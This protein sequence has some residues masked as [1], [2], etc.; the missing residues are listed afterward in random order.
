MLR[1][2]TAVQV[3]PIAGHE[4]SNSSTA[5]PRDSHGMNS[6]ARI[7]PSARL[8]LSDHRRLITTVLEFLMTLSLIRHFVFRLVLKGKKVRQLLIDG[9]REAVKRLAGTAVGVERMSVPS[10]FITAFCTQ[11]VVCPSW[12]RS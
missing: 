6:H 7:T 4:T 8:S 2:G 9:I 11:T 3:M 1:A 10:V 12:D 5:V